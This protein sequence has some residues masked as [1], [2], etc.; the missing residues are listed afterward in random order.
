[1]LWVTVVASHGQALLRP[2]R[3]GFE[4]ICAEVQKGRMVRLMAQDAYRE[5]LRAWISPDD[6]HD[7]IEFAMYVL[8]CWGHGRLV[9]R[10]V[11]EQLSMI[12]VM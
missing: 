12:L 4:Q 1:M 6:Q 8:L 7:V 2:L 3:I 9:L 5:L 10:M 11:M